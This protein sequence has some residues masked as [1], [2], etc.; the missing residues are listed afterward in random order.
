MSLE[1]AA[2][3]YYQGTGRSYLALCPEQT[4]HMNMGLWPA[5]SLCAAQEALVTHAIE[6]C[7]ARLPGLV[8]VVDAGSGWGGSARVFARRVPDAR[9][10]GVNLSTEQLER[11]RSQNA[12]LPL[13]RY[14]EGAIE[15]FVTTMEPV[16]CLISLEAAFHFEH[17]IELIRRLRGKVRL[18]TLLDI[19]A[20]ERSGV[21]EHP[22]LLPALREA[23]SL[24]QYTQAFA[25]AGFREQVVEDLSSRTFAGFSAHLSS[26]DTRSYGGN[27]AVLR[28]FRM[29]FKTMAKLHEQGALRYVLISA[30]SD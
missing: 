28:Q 25:Q 22:L 14:H 17:K 21:L 15:D 29:A 27:A 8:H 9:Y 6:H 20:E 2:A 5:E 23:F 10:T 26:L 18:V 7:L 4:G 19:C 12:H 24:A 11:A 1:R 16:D 30:L 13:V 3:Q